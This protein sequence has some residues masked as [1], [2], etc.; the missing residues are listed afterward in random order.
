MF[1][2]LGLLVSGVL[3]LALVLAGCSSAGPDTVANSFFEAVTAGD[4]EKANAMFS[5]QTDAKLT[6]P[7]E[8]EERIVNALFSKMTFEVGEPSV[9][10][11]V[12]DIQF[13]LT[14]PDM[15]RL[16]AKLMNEV[17]PVALA[18]AFDENMSDEQLNLMVEEKM[19]EI[20]NDPALA[21]V[22]SDGTITLVKESGEW[23]V[24]SVDG[25]N[26]ETTFF[27]E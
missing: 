3:T 22:T 8:D 9:S 23:M 14:M 5:A 21:Y 24:F 15:D 18:S 7:A 11:D 1:R 26:F 10:G 25:L 27:E 20:L 16:A 6:A 13:T 4:W 2:R 19:V 17:M 12:A